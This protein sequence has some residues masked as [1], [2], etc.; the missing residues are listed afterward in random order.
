[1][2]LELALAA[3]ASP[4]AIISRDLP[5]TYALAPARTPSL[6]L[7]LLLSALFACFLH[8]FRFMISFVLL[9]LFGFRLRFF[10]ISASVLF[11]PLSLC[12]ILYRRTLTA[13]RYSSQ[14]PWMLQELRN[15]VDD[16]R[17][18]WEHND[19]R[20]HFCYH[21]SPTIV[22]AQFI[23]RRRSDSFYRQIL[24]SFSTLQLFTPP[25]NC[26]RSLQCQFQE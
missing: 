7:R 24:K 10:F 2:K 14:T 17:R 18:Q 15:C 6:S 9:F 8:W 21:V 19:A 25:F 11:A 20:M 26:K 16:I 22:F 3:V 12:I 23:L 5:P 1:M 4:F 13:A